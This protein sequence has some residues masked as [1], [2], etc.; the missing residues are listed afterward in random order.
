MYRLSCT[1]GE[2]NTAFN[3][4][5]KINEKWTETDVNKKTEE[6]VTDKRMP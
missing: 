1:Y 5:C 3:L 4:E 6:D 2:T